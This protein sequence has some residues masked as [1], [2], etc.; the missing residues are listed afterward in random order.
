MIGQSA[1]KQR[2]VRAIGPK[3]STTY[4]AAAT[5]VH[6]RAS[7]SLVSATGTAENHQLSQR[8][9]S[10]DLLIPWSED[11]ARS[12]KLQKTL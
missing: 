6:G 10:L 9:G 8:I 5:D 1:P 11:Q 3:F 12:L 4:R 2:P 7:L